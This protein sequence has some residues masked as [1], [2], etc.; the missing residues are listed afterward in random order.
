MNPQPVL[1]IGD[2]LI[3]EGNWQSLLPELRVCKRGM[4]GETAQELLHRLN[5]LAPE[6]TSCDMAVIM[7]GTNNLL[8]EDYTFPQRIGDIISVLHK[9]HPEILL[10]VTSLLPFQAPWLAPGTIQRLNHMTQSICQAEQVY[11]HDLYCIFASES[12]GLFQADHIHLSETGYRVW[13]K[14]LCKIIAK[15][16]KEH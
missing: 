10:M 11:F 9:T 5:R 13:A 14:S 15:H 4:P 7:T 12:R 2:S 16:Q 8:M 1:M 6:L 3:A